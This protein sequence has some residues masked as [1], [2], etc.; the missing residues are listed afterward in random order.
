MK[1]IDK[2]V[3]LSA[4][5]T[6][7]V[8]KRNSMP[9]AAVLLAALAISVAG[10]NAAPAAT[11]QHRDQQPGSYRLKAGDLEVTGLYDG[12]GVFAPHCL[13]GTYATMDGVMMRLQ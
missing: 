4:Q 1:S 6:R 5:T 2:A 9:F 10:P 12:T 3:E 8:L 7:N 13:T 11:P